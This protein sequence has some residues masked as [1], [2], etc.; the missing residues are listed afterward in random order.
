ML[1]CIQLFRANDYRI[2]VNVGYDLLKLSQK[3]CNEISEKCMF[4]CLLI[5]IN[6]ASQNDLCV[7][8][9]K[10]VRHRNYISK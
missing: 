1:D 9:L 4:S 5:Q 7:S 2:L 3:Y 8:K 6:E 10:K